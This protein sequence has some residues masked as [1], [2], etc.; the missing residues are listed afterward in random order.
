MCSREKVGVGIIGAGGMGR[1]NLQH[2]LDAH[3]DRVE[4]RGICDPSDASIEMT[5]ERFGE[6]IP[7]YPDHAALLGAED[8]DWVVIASWNAAH[9]DQTIAAFHAGK[10]VFLQKPVATRLE[11]CVAM[12]DAWR[13]SGR[14]CVV[15]FTLR[16]S[17]FYR[18]LKEILTSGRIGYIVSMEFNETLDFN[19]GGFIHGNWRRFT[20]WAGTHL[21]EKCCHDVDLVNWM[22]ES[23]PRCVAS[24]GGLDMFHAGNRYLQDELGLSPEDHPRGGGR[25]AFATWAVPGSEDGPTGQNP[26]LA[27]K[28]IVDN[29]VA[30]IEY[31]NGVRATFHTN[32]CAG[33]PERRMYICGSRGAVRADVLTGIIEV[34]RYGWKQETERIDT[35]I[36]GGHGGGDEI[37]G[38]ELGACMV[39]G[40]TPAAD[41]D[42]GVLSAT[43][44]FA[45]DDAME[46]GEVVDCLPYWEALGVTANTNR[47]TWERGSDQ[48]V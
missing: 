5:R 11:D 2:L 8:I 23:L 44:C 10:D 29:Q 14:Q 27:E 30:I 15:G 35:G 6:D 1:G 45:I 32:C 42:N 48:G 34:C 37:M 25:P 43:A 13:A 4:I 3:G 9:A 31:A 7:V 39:E 18:Q 47:P 46:S 26:F 17:R 40:A 41:L 28:D 16:F 33:I 12:L 36:K 38:E 20:K 21:L 19:H 24:F 22:V